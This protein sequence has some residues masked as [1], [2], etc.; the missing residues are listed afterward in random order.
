MFSM[1]K[2]IT[3]TKE[4]KKYSPELQNSG[5]FFI[6]FKSKTIFI[7]LFLIN[8]KTDFIRNYRFRTRF[9]RHTKNE[10]EYGFTTGMETYNQ[11][12]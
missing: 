2:M 6:T 10:Q 4:I 5:V 1:M 8:E 3:T 9:L 12:L 7:L 11:Y